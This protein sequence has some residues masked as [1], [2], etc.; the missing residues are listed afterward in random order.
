MTI[1]RMVKEEKEARKAATTKA[2]T[3]YMGG[4]SYGVT[5][6][7]AMKMATASSIFGEPQYYRDGEYAESGVRDGFMRV[8]SIFLP[9]SIFEPA[10][11][12][13]KTSRFME[14]LIDDALSYDFGETIRW[15]RTL[16]SEYGMRLN[17]QVIM[18][19]AASHP[20][21]VAF[22]EENPGVFSEIEVAVMSRADEPAVQLAYFLHENGS[23]AAIPNVLKRGW[24][25]RLSGMSRYEAAKWKN[26]AVG[27]IDVVRLCHA[28]GEVVDEL[29][30]TGNVTVGETERT[31]ENMRSAGASWR[32]I[33]DA[34]RIPHM[35]LLRNLRGIFSEVDDEETARKV[36][37]ALKAGVKSGR[38]FPFRYMSAMNAV[39]ASDAN[40]KTMILDTLEDC[41]DLACDNLPRLKGRTMCLSDNSG[42]AWGTFNSEYG[43]VTVAEIDN[44]SAVVAARNSDEGFV[45]KFG[46]DLKTFP[47]L[48][49]NGILTQA[50]AISK[51]RCDDVGG[52]TEAGVWKFLDE[53]IRKKEK[54]D[55]VIVFSDMQAG[56]GGLYGDSATMRKARAAGDVCRNGSY[57]DVAKMIDRYRKAVNPKVNVL[58][59]QTAGYDD[60]VV[61]EYGYRT[62]LT[63][64]W[65][66]KEVA[67][68]D[69]MSRLWDEA[70]AARENRGAKSET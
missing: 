60:V 51:N 54:W 41:A 42:S 45:G 48:K 22:N 19:R 61:P 30:R 15:A 64:G 68:A 33:L 35:A 37:D 63:Y 11:S 21:R 28:K 50:K 7:E 39:E 32:E 14:R 55:N 17:P 8:N 26:G 43:T 66:G 20:N 49:R 52:A 6:V 44:L 34:I 59:V 16:R 53:A 2:V 58:C 27:M 18:V 12:E 70:D 62:C 5:P 1:G 56:H 36:L 65:T 9:F 29:M 31:W 38:Q 3:N 4:T 57:V 67:F 13:E 40:F 46:D 24:A 69:A 47:I 10:P 23:K 25:R